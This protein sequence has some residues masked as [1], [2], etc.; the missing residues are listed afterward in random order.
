MRRAFTLVEVLVVVAIIAV[1]TAISVP[2]FVS[3]KCAAKRAH[4]LSNL[5]QIGIALRLYFDDN[6]WASPPMWMPAIGQPAS[7]VDSLQ[8]YS[9][10]RLLNRSPL[11]DSPL[12]GVPNSGRRTSY[13]LNGWFDG[14]HLQTYHPGTAVLT[15]SSTAEPASCVLVAPLAVR[16]EGSDFLITGDHFMPEYWG[17]PPKLRHSQYEGMQWNPA[18]RRPRT[19]VFDQGAGSSNLLFVDG[20]AA[21]RTFSSTFTQSFGGPPAVDL[22]DPAGSSSPDL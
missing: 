21:S 18:S 9:C 15:P 4:D 12:W 19:I 6:D 14:L 3:A 2:V 11:D 20:H 13:A 8:P 5:R 17:T 1:L 16:R 22:Y 10:S 7:W